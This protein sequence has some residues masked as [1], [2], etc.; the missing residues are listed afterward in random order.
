MQLTAAIADYLALQN[1]WLWLGR[2]R[3]HLH[4]LVAAFALDASVFAAAQ[5]GLVDHFDTQVGLIL[6]RVS[7]LAAISVGGLFVGTTCIIIR[8]SLPRVAVGGIIAAHVIVAGLMLATPLWVNDDGAETPWV[9]MWLPYLV[10]VF[11]F[12]FF[13]LLRTP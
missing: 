4:L 7:A 3:E 10:W 13:R 1:F 11:A 2:R 5:A 12:S 8:A 6:I 9:L